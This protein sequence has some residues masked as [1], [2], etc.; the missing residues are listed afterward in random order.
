MQPSP[1]RGAAVG[2]E[3]ERERE[4]EGGRERES[5]TCED[6]SD[7]QAEGDGGAAAVG[8]LQVAVRHPAALERLRRRC[9]L[10]P[11]QPPPLRRLSCALA[12]ALSPVE[13]GHSEYEVL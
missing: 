6:A 10:P 5:T 9:H 2:R 12:P 7:L 3:R 8:G 1:R 11:P 13:R 4:R